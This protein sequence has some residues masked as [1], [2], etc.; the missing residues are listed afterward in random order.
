MAE[1]IYLEDL[2]VGDVFLSDHYTLDAEQIIRF[3]TEFDPQPFHLDHHA[4]RDTF[5]QGLAASGW[6]TASITMRLLVASLPL[7]RGIIGAGA[8]MAWPQATRPGD[9]L[10]V[11]SKIISIT[12]SLSKPDRGIVVVECITSNQKDEVL[13]RMVTTILCFKKS[14]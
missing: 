2:A 6:Q 4:A 9:V 5:F 8:E 1:P 3:A 12:P 10:R 11:T 7:A 14:G 13:Q